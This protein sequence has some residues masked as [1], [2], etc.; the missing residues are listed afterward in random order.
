MILKA[1]GAPLSRPLRLSLPV[2]QWTAVLG[3]SGVGKSTLLKALAGLGPDGDLTDGRTGGLAGRVAYM[4][5]SDGL[6]PWLSVADN[7][8]LGARL[9]GQPVDRVR[10]ATLLQAVGL[11][12]QAGLRPDALSGGM[13]QRAALVRTLMEDR[14]VVLMDEPFSALDPVTRLDLQDLAARTLAG[15]TVLMVTHDP[16]E[17]LRLAHRILILHGRPARLDTPIIP[18][19]VPPRS[20]TAGDLPARHAALLERLHHLAAE[21]GR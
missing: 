14:P 6:L 15:R 12:A 20:P 7:G 2:G 19:G 3:P 11:K 17:A 21:G 8:A 4:A 1:G 18:P 10:L 5:Q 13:R 9:R 16:M